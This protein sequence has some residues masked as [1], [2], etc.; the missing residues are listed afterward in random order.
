LGLFFFFK[1]R[2]GLGQTVEIAFV[3]KKRVDE[4]FNT[5]DKNVSESKK[6]MRVR[7]Y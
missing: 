5:F 3:K 4:L 7:N 6:I 1:N 2:L